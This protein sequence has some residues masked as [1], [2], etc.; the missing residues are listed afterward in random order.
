LATQ[1]GSFSP[2]SG[3]IA[4]RPVAMPRFSIVS[5]LASVTS[6]RVHSAQNAASAGSDFAASTAIGCSAATAM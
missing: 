2:V 3:W 4:K 5:R 6:V 1:I